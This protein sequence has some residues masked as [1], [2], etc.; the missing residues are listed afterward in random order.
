MELKEPQGTWCGCSMR[1]VDKG[2]RGEAGKLEETHEGPYLHKT[3]L[4]NVKHSAY[5]I[6][7]GIISLLSNL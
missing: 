3:F 5:L 1:H 2:Y 7:L 6:A 4:R